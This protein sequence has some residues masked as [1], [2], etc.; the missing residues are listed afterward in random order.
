MRLTFKSKVRVALDLVPFLVFS[1]LYEKDLKSKAEAEGLTLEEY[2][3]KYYTLDN[4]DG[5]YS[6]QFSVL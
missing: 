3:K 2:K 4:S 6:K 5:K 1:H